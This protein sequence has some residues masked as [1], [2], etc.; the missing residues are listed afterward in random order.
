MNEA[1]QN[2]TPVADS[3]EASGEAHV[4]VSLVIPA[5]TPAIDG[6]PASIEAHRSVVGAAQAALIQAL[7]ENGL[8]DAGSSGEPPQVEIGRRF[9]VVP[10][11]SAIVRSQ[12][13]LDQ[14]SA[15]P[16]VTAVQADGQVTGTLASSVPL[17]S[18]DERHVLGNRGDG[19]VVAVLDTGA[20]NDHPDLMDDLS[21][22]QACFLD[23]GGASSTC[24][25]GSVQQEGP[26]AAEDDAGHGTHVS[27]IVTSD[28]TVSSAGVAPDATVV[29]IKVLDNCTF[30]G[31]GT[32][33]EAIAGLD[34]IATNN[35]DLGVDVV[36][37]SLG[38]NTGYS[39]DCDT[40]EL[41]WR[42]AVAALNGLGITVV[43]AAGNNGDSQMRAP[44]CIAA[45]VS[46]G[47]ADDAD[48]PAGDSNS[49]PTTDL[50]APGVSITS[51][52][53]GGGTVSANG[54]SMASPHVAGC[55]A[56]IIEAGGATG[57][58]AIEARLETSGD[59]VTDRDGRVYPRLDCSPAVVPPVSTALI[60][61]ASGSMRDNDPDD[62]RLS[63]G[64]TYLSVTLPEDEVGLVQ[65]ATNASILSEAI[66]VAANRPLLESQINSIGSSGST[67]LGGAALRGC[68]VL[69]RASG[70]DRAAILLTDGLPFPDPYQNEA[71]CF[72]DQGWPVYT[73]GLSDAVDETLLQQIADSTGGTYTQLTEATDLVCAFA[74]IRAEIAGTATTTCEPT[75][76]ITQG[77]TISFTER[78]RV[79][80]RQ[81]TFL[82]VWGGSDIEMTVTSPT[83]RTIDRNSTG[84]DLTI[85]NGPTF[86]SITVST[87]EVGVW[88]IDLFGADIPAGG[89]QFTYLS[90]QIP[91]E[92]QDSDGDGIDDA[93]D[94]CIDVPNPDQADSDGD[95]IGDACDE[96]D[97]IF[98][99]GS[100]SGTKAELEDLGYN[101][102]I[103]TEG[104]DSLNLQG[105]DKPDFV[106]G[107]GGNDV[108][109][110]GAGAD[111]VCGGDGNDRI[112]L[113]S[114]D[115]TA[116]GQGGRD[117]LVG[118]GGADTLNGGSG[119]DVIHGGDN[120]DWISAG[121]GNDL[122]TGGRGD[123]DLR[124]GAGND[125]LGG[126]NGAD[127][128]RGG[129]GD[130]NLYGNFG[131]DI[132]SGGGGDDR[133][134]GG[135]QD[136][137]IK[138]TCEVIRQ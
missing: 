120:D 97:E 64:R 58:A 123:D 131:P 128:L 121:S 46:V 96:D 113:G 92:S 111:V 103:G 45:V 31:C 15:S 70:E 8:T 59:E 69:G 51:L 108:I 1:S 74:Q 42:D 117:R 110:T 49:S 132:I 52:A 17:I 12:A 129:G 133:C 136:D 105:S 85:D 75:A 76:T 116:Y 83:G 44:A 29:P 84:A 61:D 78:V 95:G 102:V 48:N 93:V 14:L 20:D 130:D 109:R 34:W 82:N 26:G 18:A 16:H 115:D 98:R 77:E 101:V 4:I 13:A 118:D 88:D 137:D 127:V 55:A 23:F 68:D 19:V 104:K 63:A 90:L 91:V 107:L 80:V 72:V 41:A 122:A 6:T 86:E 106:L 87:P 94:N 71:Q 30:A 134:V 28:G 5:D 11:I 57:P 9:E 65:F 54:T 119:R 24:P 60:I 39:G 40:S 135:P 3:I 10:A 126:G 21:D 27:G 125:T 99:C 138:A 100:V 53:V 22:M 66:E 35:A 47:S 33:S 67:D 73:I 89:E 43:A 79:P 81:I 124:G 38:A 114:G 7:A 2:S 25:D 62:L 37:L 36:N 56:L 50:F 32:E 112:F